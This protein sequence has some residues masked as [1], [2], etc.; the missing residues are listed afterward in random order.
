MWFINDDFSSIRAHHKFTTLI[1]I[2]IFYFLC[3]SINYGG[4]SNNTMLL[5][6]HM[7]LFQFD[8]Q[9]SKNSSVSSSSSSGG[10][11]TGDT[12][13]QSHCNNLGQGHSAQ[14]GDSHHQ[15]PLL[16]A[17][18]R[19]TLVAVS[20]D[21]SIQTKPLACEPKLERDIVD[22]LDTISLHGLMVSDLDLGMEQT[23]INP[24]VLFGLL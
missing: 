20:S 17:T 3:M 13:D 7:P 18:I 16:S 1:Y 10:D 2:S 19:Q 6:S 9:T 8:H 15:H 23:R 21:H 11:D 12:F 4:V 5:E 14:M 24:K 22:D